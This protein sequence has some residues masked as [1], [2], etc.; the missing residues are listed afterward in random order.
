MAYTT[1]QT[2][3]PP[4]H[5]WTRIVSIFNEYANLLYIGELIGLGFSY[6]DD[7]VNSTI[8]SAL[9]AWKLL[10]IFFTQFLQY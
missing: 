1:L 3:L 6:G 7:D 10:Q 9:C 8:A 2:V 4:L 5:F